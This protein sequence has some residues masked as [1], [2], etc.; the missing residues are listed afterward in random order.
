MID[1]YRLLRDYRKVI[2]D[3][4][5]CNDFCPLDKACKSYSKYDAHLCLEDDD[6][7]IKVV[8]E[9]YEKELH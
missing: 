8:K 4:V 7:F 6:I 1:I 3:H 2:D 9:Y 5:P